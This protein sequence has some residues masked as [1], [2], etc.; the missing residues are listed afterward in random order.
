MECNPI[1][2]FK[3]KFNILDY[4]DITPALPEHS[5]DILNYNLPPHLCKWKHIP[6]PPVITSEWKTQEITRILRT[7]VWIFIKKQPVWIPPFYYFFLQYFQVMGQPAQFRLKRLKH[8][9]FKIR[10]RKN[11]RAI[12]TFTIKNRQDGETTMAM[13]ESLWQILE[14]NMDFGG[15]GVQSKTRQTVVESCWRVFVMGF[16]G[17]PRWLKE[18]LLH[19]VVS[20][21]K[22]ATKM[23]V[24][25]TADEARG[26][27][28]K[29]ILVTYGSSVHNA[30]DSMSNMQRC[31]LDEFCKWEECSPY[32]TF[33]NYEKFIAPGMS[34]KGLFDIFS[35]PPDKLGRY[36]EE[37]VSFWKGSDGDN[38]TTYGSTETRVFRYYSN[39]LEGIEDGYDEYGD[40]DADEIFDFIMNRRKSLPKDQ[41]LGEIRGYPLNESEIFGSYEGGSGFDNA[42]GIKDRIIYLTGTRFKNAITQEPVR[43]FGNHERVDGYIDG[44]VEFR[45]S[46]KDYFDLIDSRVCYSFLPQNKEPLVNVFKPPAYIE[47][48]IG[49]DPFNNR[50][51]AKSV[52]KQSNAAMVGR[53]FRDIFETGVLNV[54]FMTYCCRPQHQ[55]TVWEDAIKAAIYNRAM[56]QV[57]S[58]SDKFANYAEDRGYS[59]WLLNER[60]DNTGLR[61]GDAPSGGKNAFL[62]EGIGLINANT[63]VPLGD[64]PYWLQNHWHI[65]LLQDYLDL[66]P[67]DTHANDLTMADIQALVGQVKIMHTKVRQPSEFNDVVYNY[68]FN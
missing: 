44:E 19:D 32:A 23:Q 1:T 31:I 39:P 14:G 45:P 37:I 24:K 20:E 17:V 27:T 64:I 15:I 16:N 48:V 59:H 26:I 28:A 57:E 34:R 66:N 21:D 55:E 2:G 67:L 35:S 58:K 46:G 4:A 5:K 36:N 40:A 60:G 61:K 13:A 33:L 12:G 9:Y 50:Y 29:D 10:V 6:P 47:R 54:P 65:E 63:N 30:F 18:I 53:Q 8:V 51:E 3:V 56:L 52:V 68:L 49:L 7:G 25:R 41:L 22:L 38:L 43:I 62:N 42:E 11:P